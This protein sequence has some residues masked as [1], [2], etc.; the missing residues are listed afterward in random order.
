MKL[1]AVLI[2]ILIL[3]LSSAIAWSP[4]QATLKEG[5]TPKP[6]TPKSSD[7]MA[8]P[9]PKMTI[10]P[11]QT[12]VKIAPQLSGGLFTSRKK[13]DAMRVEGARKAA[14]QREE[15]VCLEA[16]QVANDL[17]YKPVYVDGWESA[18][19]KAVRNTDAGVS[20]SDVLKEECNQL[21]KRLSV[22]TESRM[23]IPLKDPKLFGKYEVSFV[24]TGSS[25]R[26]NPAG[27]KYRSKLGRLFYRNDGLYQHILS[28]E[29]KEATVV[30]NYI[31][32]TLLSFI[33]F[34]V[35]LKG[36]ATSLKDEERQNVT[37]KFG[38]VLSPSTVQADFS[39]PLIVIGNLAS[40]WKGFSFNA[41][42]KSNVIL[43]ESVNYEFC[44]SSLS[45]YTVSHGCILF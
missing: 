43:G 13:R 27:G 2:L 29:D 44:I 7:E 4:H 31:R 23:P 34:A 3:I 45:Y 12:K 42:P 40:R 30:L 25:Q 20:A 38:Q 37:N 8:E 22:A 14:R 17:K 15:L 6:V 26:G 19:L 41:G 1:C 5:V 39:P 21:I 28:E 24:G 35:I 18:L 11:L 36:I 9:W 16:I 10:A 32:G 33:P